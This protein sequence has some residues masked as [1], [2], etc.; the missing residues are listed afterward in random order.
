VSDP[1]DAARAAL[2][3]RQG[4]GARYDADNAPAVDLA[5]ARSATAYFARILNGMDDKAL[6]MP[7]DGAGATRAHI[8]A[9]VGLAARV[10]AEIL[11][12]MRQGQA[13]GGRLPLHAAAD[14]DA[15][16]LGATLPPGALRNLIFHSTVHLDVEW[17]DLP[18]AAWDA[19]AIDAAGTEIVIRDL[20]RARAVS[21]WTA[22]LDLRAGAR[23][24]DV[25]A[26]LRAAM[27]SPRAQQ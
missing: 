25:P 7:L 23:L 3:A 20:P 15:V 14:P 5:L 18:D 19:R 13:E 12:S 17:R 16:A 6:F 27:T 22:A 10:Q 9:G 8:V 4:A 24:A 21:L 26:E 2:R 11:A 1:L